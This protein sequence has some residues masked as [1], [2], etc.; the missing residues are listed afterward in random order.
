MRRRGFTLQVPRPK[1]RRAA[2][3]D[4]AIRVQKKLG[5]TLADRARTDTEETGELWTQ[6]EARLGLKPLLRRQWSA[7]GQA[8]SRHVATRF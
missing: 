7:R 1:P 8:S 6:D 4:E 5:E 2:T 3:A